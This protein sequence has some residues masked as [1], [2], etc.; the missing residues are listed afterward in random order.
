M[1][2][3]SRG[4]TVDRHRAR[5]QRGLVV[6]QVAVSLVLV[7]SALLF[8]RT[9]RNLASV[10]TGFEADRTF[11]VSFADRASQDLPVEHKVAFQEQ[12]T[13]EIRSLPGVAAAAS[14]THIPLSGDMW[15]H[16][17]RVMGVAGNETQG[18]AIR[19]RQ[20]RVLRHAEDPH[21]VGP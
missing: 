11:A 15:S 5:F 19:V 6:V 18:V 14:S 4:L 2:Q 9:F 10:D 21:T 8:F 7:F 20:P 12:L 17:F 1:R 13:S 16:F 3:A